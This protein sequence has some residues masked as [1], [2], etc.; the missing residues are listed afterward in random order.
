[1]VASVALGQWSGV[2]KRATLVPV[3]FTDGD[4]ELKLGAVEAALWFIVNDI[5]SKERDTRAIINFSYG[6]YIR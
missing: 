1:M 5:G 6:K 2:A 4:S 3:K